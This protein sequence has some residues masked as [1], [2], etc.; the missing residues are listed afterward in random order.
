MNAAK[1]VFVL[2]VMAPFQLLVE[3]PMVT[4]CGAEADP[5]WPLCET[6]CHRMGWEF[7]S[8]SAGFFLYF[9]LRKKNQNA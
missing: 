3:H 1:V 5:G 9:F 8:H 4:F 7:F 2:K 6:E